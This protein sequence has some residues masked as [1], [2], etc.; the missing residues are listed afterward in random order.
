MN[1]EEELKKRTRHADEVVC[2][3]LPAVEG[4]DET[5]LS[6]MNYSVRAGGKRLRPL[7]IES[8]CRI[9]CTAEM[10]NWRSL[11]WLPWK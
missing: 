7:M 1:F 3:F 5:L 4:A 8:T 11:S 9:G 6:A 2:S 10:K